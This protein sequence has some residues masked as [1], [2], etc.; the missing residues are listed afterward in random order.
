MVNSNGMDDFAQELSARR[1]HDFEQRNS[2][3]EELD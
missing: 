1:R 2:S 3:D